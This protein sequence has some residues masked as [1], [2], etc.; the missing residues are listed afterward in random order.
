MVKITILT[1]QFNVFTFMVT[2]QD[3]HD[4]AAPLTLA[5]NADFQAGRQPGPRKAHLRWGH[6]VTLQGPNLQ[7]AAVVRPFD[8]ISLLR[9]S[10]NGLPGSVVPLRNFQFL[11]QQFAHRC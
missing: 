5:A 2:A 1:E 7:P 4:F 9:E 6:F 3:I 8:R 11:L 10:R